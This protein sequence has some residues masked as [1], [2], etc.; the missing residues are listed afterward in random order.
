M[1]TARQVLWLVAVLIISI[2]SALF[3]MSQ[4]GPQEAGLLY[5]GLLYLLIFVASGSAATLAGFYL[6]AGLWGKKSPYPL[7]STAKRQGA[8]LG[9]FAVAV[10]VLKANS[11]LGFWTALSLFIIVSLLE[12]Y[13]VSR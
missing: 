7:L 8:F 12:L 6:R 2:L 13:A 1:K 9:A 4:K 5:I 3:L 11:L 10:M